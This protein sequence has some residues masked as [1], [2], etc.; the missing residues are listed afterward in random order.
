MLILWRA[1]KEWFLLIVYAFLFRLLKFLQ[2]LCKMYNLAYE[3][4]NV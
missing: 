1:I 4:V 2:E 3:Q